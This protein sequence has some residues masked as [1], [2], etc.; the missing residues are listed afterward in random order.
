M[1]EIQSHMREQVCVG[2]SLQRTQISSDRLSLQHL[3]ERDIL[4]MHFY[5]SVYSCSSIFSGQT[6]PTLSVLP[7]P[8]LQATVRTD[9]QNSIL[10]RTKKEVEHIQYVLTYRPKPKFSSGQKGLWKHKRAG[11]EF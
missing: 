11:A 2:F 4:T 5:I 9:W 7:L 3:C 10:P 8:C 1:S 6:F